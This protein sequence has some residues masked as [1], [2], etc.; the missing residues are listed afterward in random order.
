MAVKKMGRPTIFTKE[1]AD[2]ICFRISSGESLRSIVKDKK[3]PA[4]STILLWVIDGKHSDFSE[5]YTQ[6]CA[7]RAESLFE[8]ALEIADEENEDVSRSRLRVD[9]RKWYLSKVLPKKFG[10]KLDLTSGGKPIPILGGVTRKE[11][12]KGDL[13]ENSKTDGI[14]NNNGDEKSNSTQETN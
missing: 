14:Y 12:A 7:T 10:E 9:T 2:K 8:E 4:M 6:A 11:N 3:I 5:Q 1:L 13:S